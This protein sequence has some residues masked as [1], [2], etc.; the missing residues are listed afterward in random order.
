MGGTFY[1]PSYPDINSF[2]IYIGVIEKQ[3]LLHDF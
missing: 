2:K 3:N 1:P